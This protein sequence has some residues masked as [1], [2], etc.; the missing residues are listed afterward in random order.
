MQFRKTVM[1]RRGTS[2]GS[3][4]DAVPQGDR[5]GANERPYELADLL[6]RISDENLQP[7]R[8]TGKPQGNEQW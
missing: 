1:E 3:G 5:A 7:E 4:I 2:L 8:G 6:G